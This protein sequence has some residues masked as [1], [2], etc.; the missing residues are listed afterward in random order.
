MQ[1]YMGHMGGGYYPNSQGYN[2]YVN[3]PY[4]NQP[5]LGTWNTMEQPSL[6]FLSTLNL[7]D[8]SK[9]TNDLVSHDPTWLVVPS[10]I[11]LDIAK[12]EGNNGEDPGEHVSTFHLWFSSN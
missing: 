8:L 5:L 1:P 11:S 4:V 2:L 6:P 7:P 3:R 12:F 10:K 9:L